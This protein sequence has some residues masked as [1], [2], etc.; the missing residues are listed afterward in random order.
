LTVEQPENMKA[1]I[2][3]LNNINF[4]IISCYFFAILTY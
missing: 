3:K 2:V 4:F 1:L